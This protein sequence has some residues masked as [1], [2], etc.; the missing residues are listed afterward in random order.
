LFVITYLEK[1][2]ALTQQPSGGVS[3]HI[4]AVSNESSNSGQSSSATM[5]A[6]QPT[7]NRIM[8][9]ANIN[10]RS[11]TPT[12]LLSGDATMASAATSKSKKHQQQSTTSGATSTKKRHAR[13]NHAGTL[14][15]T[16]SVGNVSGNNL[17]QM[18]SAAS[19]GDDNSNGWNNNNNNNNNNSNASQIVQQQQQPKLVPIQKFCFLRWE[20]NV[21][22]LVR[23]FII[24]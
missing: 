23:L 16:S 24:A 11:A 21:D 10:K 5:D 12:P 6:S 9:D 17:S 4:S 3:F 7:M 18:S 1:N 19:T 13:H 20:I 2:L 14:D 15:A 8:S 22:T